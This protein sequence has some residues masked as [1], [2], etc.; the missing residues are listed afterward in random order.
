M[1]DSTQLHSLNLDT[2]LS[3]RMPIISGEH[4][5]WLLDNGAKLT[6]FDQSRGDGNEKLVAHNTI[7]WRIDETRGHK[8]MLQ[9][10]RTPPSQQQ[11]QLQRS[12]D[13]GRL[14]LRKRELVTPPSPDD[15]HLIAD[16]L[17]YGL[18]IV[19]WQGIGNKA[20]GFAAYWRCIV[21]NI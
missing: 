16:D 1:F 21:Y 20:T 4:A 5:N 10:H 7:F 15:D 17:S 19:P 11:Q 14:G 9:T 12:N 8:K 6:R 3:G 13:H 2:I 18:I